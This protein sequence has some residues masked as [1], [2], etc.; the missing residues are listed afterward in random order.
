LIATTV[1]GELTHNFCE[2]PATL[3]E[4]QWLA[5]HGD[6]RSVTPPST[7]LLDLVA[8]LPEDK[9]KLN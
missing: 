2:L 4:T 3:S 9:E 8:E 5:K 7:R 1:N 6:G